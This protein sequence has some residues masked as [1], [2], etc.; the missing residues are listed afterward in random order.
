M[1]LPPLLPQAHRAA[2]CK[3]CPPRRR[4]V[5]AACR[6]ELQQPVFMAIDALEFPELHDESIPALAFIRHL[7]RLMQASGVRDFSLKA[8]AA[9]AAAP[10]PACP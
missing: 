8:R 9:L 2:C 4:R 7:T 6:E 3:P 5:P 10:A 1:P